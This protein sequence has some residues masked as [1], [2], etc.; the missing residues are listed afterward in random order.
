[1]KTLTPAGILAINPALAAV[2]FGSVGADE[3]GL[4]AGVRDAFRH[5]GIVVGVAA[6]GALMRLAVF[7]RVA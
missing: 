3:S 7:D 4:A 1:M 6:V 2:A 5:A